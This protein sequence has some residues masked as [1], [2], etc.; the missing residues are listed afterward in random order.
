MKEKNNQSLRKSYIDYALLVIGS[1]LLA[2]SIT[3][4]LRPN[5]LI[6][7]GI[8]GISILLGGFLGVP[9]TIYYYVLALIVLTATFLTLGKREVK[10]IIVYSILFPLILIMFESL[11]FRLYL[12]DM[13]LAAIFYGLIAGG[14]FGLVVSSGFASG[15]TDTIAK[16]LHNRLFPF[17]GISKLL[18]M[19]DVLVIMLSILKYDVNTALYAIVTLVVFVKSMESVIYGFSS[20]K[21]KL[22]I[23]TD[24][25]EDIENYI[26]NTVVRGVSKY[27]IIGGYTKMEKTVLTTI[28][29]PRESIMIKHFISSV[30]QDAF[31]DV[32]PVSTVWGK[33]AGFEPLIDNQ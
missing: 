7:G 29:T 33:G 11:N 2:F 8:T 13:F 10:K 15:G 14:G 32:L 17:I 4:I 5:E 24:R 1:A 20:K 12:N 21:V 27:K 31:I 22:E 30:D 23:I 25:I 26:L 9:Y 3:A 28:C 6:T 18:L 19:I 16:I